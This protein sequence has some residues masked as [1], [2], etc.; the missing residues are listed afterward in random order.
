MMLPVLRAEEALQSVRIAQVAGGQFEKGS[1][2]ARAAEGTLDEWA[3]ATEGRDVGKTRKV[4]AEDERAKTRSMLF[5][6]GVKEVKK[7]TSD[8]NA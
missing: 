5:D 2:G 1:Q 8:G 4:K 7:E 3:A 6:I